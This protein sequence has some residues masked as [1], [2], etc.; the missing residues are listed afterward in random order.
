M[1]ALLDVTRS[2][3]GVWELGQENHV[4]GTF[5]SQDF[6]VLLWMQRVDF[7]LSL[8][9]REKHHRLRIPCISGRVMLVMLMILMIIITTHP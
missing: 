1:S 8:R 4:G 5:C 2:A 6:V 3:P 7:V 9:L